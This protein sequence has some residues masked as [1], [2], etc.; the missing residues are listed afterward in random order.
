MIKLLILIIFQFRYLSIIFK[1]KNF[2]TKKLK[3]KKIP[4]NYIEYLP[5]LINNF[6]RSRICPIDFGHALHIINPDKIAGL[7]LMCLLI[8]ERDNAGVALRDILNQ[9]RLGVQPVLVVYFEPVPEVHE[10][11]Q[12]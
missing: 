6:N 9:V 7:E 4:L 1:N 12:K 8:D 2:P 3:N 10:R 5:I 11:K